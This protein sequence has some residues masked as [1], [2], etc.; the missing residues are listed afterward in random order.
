MITPTFVQAIEFARVAHDGEVRKGTQVPYLSHLLQVAGLALEF[1]ATEV[2]AIAALLHD[3]AE[4]AGGEAML[5]QIREQFGDEVEAIVRA[6]SDSITASKAEKAPWRQRKEEYLAGIAHKSESALLVSVCDKIHNARS[7]VA[8]SRAHGP[9]HWD[10]FN[11]SKEDS[12]WYYRSLLTEF[13]LRA[14]DFPRLSLAVAVFRV[15][16]DELTSVA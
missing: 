4:D 5:T 8:D 2:E 7:L 1:G 16:V 9:Q 6:N 13:E 15:A 14:D 10:R 3:A 12:L 11:A